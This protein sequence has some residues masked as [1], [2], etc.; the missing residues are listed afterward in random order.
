M[1]LKDISKYNEFIRDLMRMGIDPNVISVSSII[2]RV[3]KTNNELDFDTNNIIP[4]PFGELIKINYNDNQIEIYSIDNFFFSEKIVDLNNGKVNYEKIGDINFLKDI[5]FFGHYL[6][7]FILD[8]IEKD[9]S[10]ERRIKFNNHTK[11]EI[12]KQEIKNDLIKEELCKLRIRISPNLSNY[13]AHMGVRKIINQIEE[14]YSYRNTYK[15]FESDVLSGDVL[16]LINNKLRLDFLKKE[17]EKS[18]SI[19][20]FPLVDLFNEYEEYDSNNKKAIINCNTVMD[21]TNYALNAFY[22]VKDEINKK[23]KYLSV[24]EKYAKL[25]MKLFLK[26]SKELN[27]EEK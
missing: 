12:K 17:A 22:K 26:R 3:V 15:V 14:A 24:E 25:N 13:Y 21:N 2:N 8:N 1:Q 16:W 9:Y 5:S 7:N 6:Y 27:K 11:C 20:I 10:K 4:G 23:N 18:N 19:S